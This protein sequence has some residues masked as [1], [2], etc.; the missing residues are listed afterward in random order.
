VRIVN[1][2]SFLLAIISVPKLAYRVLCGVN[3]TQLFTNKAKAFLSIVIQ[4]Y[5][6]RRD[7][8]VCE[9]KSILWSVDNAIK[10]TVALKITKP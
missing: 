3:L 5:A 2:L 7:F 8:G 1:K 6:R 4:R 9:S 10:K